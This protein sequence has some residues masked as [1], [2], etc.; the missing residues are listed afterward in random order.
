MNIDGQC[1]CGHVTFQAEI[2]PSKVSICHCTD[3][4]MLTGSA[5]R[6]TAITSHDSIKLTGNAPKVYLKVGENGHKRLQYFCPE[7][8]SPLFTFGESADADE[9]GIR[10]G[11]RAVQRCRFAVTESA[12]QHL[13]V[14]MWRLIARGIPEPAVV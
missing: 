7:C 4:Q 2:D 10:W 1:H 5:Y 9:W 11:S 6:I 12:L 8:G 14:E 13:M 3:C